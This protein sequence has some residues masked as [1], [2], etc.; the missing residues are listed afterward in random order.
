MRKY[1]ILPNVADSRL[2]IEG[3]SL[4]ELFTSA[5]EGLAFLLSSSTCTNTPAGSYVHTKPIHITATS[6]N[7]LLVDYLSS[8]LS[9]SQ[10]D[11]NVYCQIKINK[12]DLGHLEGILY[13]TEVDHFEHSIKGVPYTD[14][15]IHKNENNVYETVVTLDM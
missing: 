11:K 1:Q 3:T 12:L 7:S 5:A 10:I 8:I 15:N 14:V 13:G 2:Q 6:Y 4:E 9:S